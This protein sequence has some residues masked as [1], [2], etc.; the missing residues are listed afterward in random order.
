MHD[1]TVSSDSFLTVAETITREFKEKGSRFIGHLHRA[2]TADAAEEII[3]K[4]RKKYFDASHNCFAW[5]LGE[6]QFRYSDD[7][8]PSGSA[9]KPIFNVLKG[10][11][12]QQLVCVVTRYF[13]GTKLGVGGLVRAYSA[14]AAL[15]VEDA[16]KVRIIQY[17]QI[18]FSHLYDD[19]S[20]IMH[21]IDKYDG[22]II[23][24]DYRAEVFVLAE[25]RKSAIAQFR[26]DLTEATKGRVTFT[27]KT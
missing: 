27:E 2:G 24:S 5:Y 17:G 10:S 23:E 6:D 3:G 9:G 12:M 16:S 20:A 25:I 8:E 14:S 15:C 11:G 13:G 22:K 26:D 19:T 21:Y 18:G 4:Y 7:G 1:K